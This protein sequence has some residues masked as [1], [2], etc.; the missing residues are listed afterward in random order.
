MF[1]KLSPKMKKINI[2][3]ILLIIFFT[4]EDIFAQNRFLNFSDVHF[5]P[6]Y[7]ST[8]V[9]KLI[10]ADYKKWEKIFLTSKNDKLSSYGDDSNYPLFK[11]ALKDMKSRIPDPDFIIITGDFMS[12]NFN[13]NFKK[14]SGLQNI[15]ALN[16]FIRKT[17]KFT[18][19]MISKYFPSIQIFVTVGNDDS[20]CGNYMV[21][22]EGAFLNMFYSAW[23]QNINFN[24]T[25]FPG[26]FK[27]GGYG[28]ADFSEDK[29]FK[30]IILNTI[31]FSVNYRNLCGD[32]LQD[33]GEDE[34][35][36][37]RE[38][39]QQCK[40]KNHKVWLSYHI[41]PG[42]DIFGTIHGKGNCEQ[43]IFPTWKKNY[44]EEFLE[45]IRKYPEVINSTFAG[46][47]HRDDF[48][49]ILNN[50]IP[51]S[52]IHLTPSISP[53][54]GNNPAYEIFE[55]DKNN[56][57]LTNYDAY[58]LSSITSSSP[59]WTFEY[60]FQRSFNQ[61]SITP[62]SLF[63]ITSLVNSDSSYRVKY[64]NFYTAGN[65]KSFP[66]DYKN[67]YYNYCGL[68]NLI[69]EEYAK[70]LCRDSLK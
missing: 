13:E 19:L 66:G 45:I 11:S 5:D 9:K 63:K 16:S 4:N 52:Y 65:Q 3:F 2:A 31:F 57:T 24:N 1:I 51:V 55:Y 12:H 38:T 44:N 56:F 30:M 7:D 53:I 25:V 36:W 27:K 32:T 54:Y 18:R 22:P 29:N 26:T 48:R 60:N 64:I 15:K 35:Q 61:S 50:D 43:K 21:E 14:Y 40:D 6:F 47:F 37:L 10:K 8:L 42:I 17:I 33:P 49:V 68:S 34:L 59:F 62:S 41:P 28:I 58:N 46:H 70:C 67:W 69:K 39:L 23:K 20:Y